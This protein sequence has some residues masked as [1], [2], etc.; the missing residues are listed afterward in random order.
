MKQVLQ[1]P[2]LGQAGADAFERSAPLRFL[3]VGLGESGY[4]M[5]KWCLVQVHKK[6]LW[7]RATDISDGTTSSS[8]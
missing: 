7:T 8:F 4:A 3:I 6:I 2:F 5:A 1:K